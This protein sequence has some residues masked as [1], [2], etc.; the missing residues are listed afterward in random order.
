[1]PGHARPARRC[2]CVAYRVV[3]G[4]PVLPEGFRFVAA[5][6]GRFENLPPSRETCFVT[7]LDQFGAPVFGH[8][9]RMESVS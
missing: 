5:N 9:N 6:F 8:L 4:V 7:G 1:M 3:Q 2:R